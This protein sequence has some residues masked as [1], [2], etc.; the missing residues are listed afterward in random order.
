[1]ACNGKMDL[2]VVKLFQAAKERARQIAEALPKRGMFR[3]GGN[4]SQAVSELL[5]TKRWQSHAQMISHEDAPDPKIGLNVTYLPPGSD[6][7]QAYWR[8]YCLQRLAVGDKQKL[9]ESDY[10]S[11][12]MEGTAI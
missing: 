10:A 6:E 3:N 5:D 7:W 1:M 8:L 4:W 12:I 9:Y 2:A 11:L